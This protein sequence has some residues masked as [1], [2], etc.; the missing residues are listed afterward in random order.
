MNF[1]TMALSHRDEYIGTIN[2]ITLG[3]E[4]V[5]NNSVLLGK[6]RLSVLL[7]LGEELL[8]S[9]TCL[10]QSPGAKDIWPH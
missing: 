1:V 2:S 4:Q 3:E 9:G 5:N 7:Q 6:K 10:M 8:Y